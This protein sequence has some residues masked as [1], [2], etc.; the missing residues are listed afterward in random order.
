MNFWDI[1]LGRKVSTTK[2]E[3][4]SILT[5]CNLVTFGKH[6]QRIISWGSLHKDPSYDPL[7]ILHL[8]LQL[9]IKISPRTRK[10]EVTVNIFSYDCNGGQQ[11]LKHKGD[12]YFYVHKYVLKTA[13]VQV[14]DS[15]CFY[16]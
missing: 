9:I 3:E 2:C 6:Y 15:F 13:N 11:W 10:C 16:V 4:I 12:L 1:I 14:T 7:Q 5:E 8:S